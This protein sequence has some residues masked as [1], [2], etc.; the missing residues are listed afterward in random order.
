MPKIKLKIWKDSSKKW[1]N[2]EEL[3][4]KIPIST[5][6][7]PTSKI[8]IGDEDYI[9]CIF[10]GLIDKNGEEIYDGDI[11]KFKFDNGRGDEE[12]ID[13]VEDWSKHGIIWGHQMFSPD[14]VEVIGNFYENPNFIDNN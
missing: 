11:I 14:E 1:L 9:P 4:N 12:F 10:T 3:L 7:K 13:L 2:H 6:I 8:S 5:S